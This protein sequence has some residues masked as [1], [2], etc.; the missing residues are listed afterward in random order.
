MEKLLDLDSKDYNASHVEAGFIACVER[1][2]VSQETYRDAIRNDLS[3]NWLCVSCLNEDIHP[4]GEQLTLAHSMNNSISFMPDA[5]ST[6]VHSSPI[7]IRQE[8]EQLT[9]ATSHRI[10]SIISS[11]LGAHTIGTLNNTGSILNSSGSSFNMEIIDTHIYSQEESLN[12]DETVNA[13]PSEN[14]QIVYEIVNTGSQRGKPMLIDCRGY[15]FTMKVRGE[16]VTRWTCSRRSSSYHCKA[17]V[18]QTRNTV[19]FAY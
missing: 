9:L 6:P 15:S 14:Q 12:D 1:V 3:I 2:G 18:S 16:N 13:H 4:E 7:D 5:S 19:V 10:D 11:M 17:T 8:S